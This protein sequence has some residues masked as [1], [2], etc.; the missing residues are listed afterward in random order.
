MNQELQSRKNQQQHNRRVRLMAASAAALTSTVSAIAVRAWM[1]Q[2]SIQL[3]TQPGRNMGNE[4]PSDFKMPYE[5]VWFHS[6][7]GIK[8]HGWFIPAPEAKATVIIAHG[9]VSSKEPSLS[10]AKFLWESGYSCFLFDFRGHGRSGDA[11]ISIS[12]QERLDVH[13]AVDYL[14]GR[15][16]KKLALYGFSMGAGVGII[17]TAENP[18]IQAL[19][20]DSAFGR[21]YSSVATHIVALQPWVPVWFSRWLARFG[22]KS[23]ANYFGYNPKLADPETF[24][25][26]IAPRPI[27]II[28]GEKDMVTPLPNAYWLYEAAGEN[29]E[30]WIQPELPHCCGFDKLGDEYKQRILQ[31]LDKVTWQEP[32]FTSDYQPAYLS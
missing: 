21:L 13:G 16:E 24:V 22:V 4:T 10:V 31:F 27:F 12:Y 8:L 32:T 25:N 6:R 2:L 11:R 7:D 9:Y 15:G 20:S 14:R 28:H 23:V 1:R 19:I 18:Y 17:A 29:K 3:I 26:R 5:E 30:L